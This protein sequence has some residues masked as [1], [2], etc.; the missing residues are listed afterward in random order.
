MKSK[1]IGSDIQAVEIILQEWESIKSESWAFVYMDD[2]IE[3]ETKANWWI[4]WMAKRFLTWESLF[5]PS[6]HNKTNMEKKVVFSAPYPWSI[7][8]LSLSDL[9]WEIYC[10]KDSFLCAEETVDISIALTK[11]IWAGL[12][13]WEWF[14]L[15]K[16]TWEGS[17]FI[18]IWWT[19]VE[20]QLD[21]WEVIKVDTWCL[22]AF[23]KTV[24]YDIKMIRWVKNILF[25]WEWLFFANLRWPW[26]VYLQSLPF[27]RIADRIISWATASGE[28]IIGWNSLLGGFFWG[29]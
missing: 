29:D 4:I 21:D 26:K 5:V 12:F 13:W 23:E 7:I 6:F 8:E 19:L 25:G 22:A 17:A 1:I 16:I 24:D 3:I 20:K 28:S 9:S 15:Q 14:I 2:W 27:S 11:K 18:H 10:Q